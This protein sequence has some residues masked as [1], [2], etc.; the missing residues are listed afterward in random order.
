MILSGVSKVVSK[1]GT[2]EIPILVMGLDR[3]GKS[4][5]LTRIKACSSSTKTQTSSSD[6]VFYMST[7]E[8]DMRSYSPTM[9]FNSVELG[10]EKN[11]KL[12]LKE[13]GGMEGL[14]TQWKFHY[15]VHVFFIR[16]FGGN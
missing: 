13:L 7:S 15:Q 5:I 8:E 6:P 10:R 3:A 4:T 16:A 12:T 11:V 1:L 14:R 2:E 9:G